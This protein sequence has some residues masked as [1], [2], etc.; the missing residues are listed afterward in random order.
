ME[1]KLTM[2]NEIII[3]KPLDSLMANSVAVLEDQVAKLQAKNYLHIILDLS[4]AAMVDSTG[5]GACMAI[6]RRLAAE[7]GQLVCIGL[8]ENVRRTFHLTRVDQKIQIY[9]ARTDAMAAMLQRV[10][11]QRATSGA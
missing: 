10:A 1:I 4:S 9:E 11:S 3:L 8:N 2:D 7:S 5:L 6:S